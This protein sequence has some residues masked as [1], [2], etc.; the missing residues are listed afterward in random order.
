MAGPTYL[1]QI[2]TIATAWSG[3]DKPTITGGGAGVRV[4]RFTGAAFVG[5][6]ASGLFGGEFILGQAVPAGPWT[7]L[8]WPPGP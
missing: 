3:N 1:S 4:L 6:L 2:P 5:V 7:L 8:A